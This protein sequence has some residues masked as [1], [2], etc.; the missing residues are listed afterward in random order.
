MNAVLEA[1][2]HESPMLRAVL[3]LAGGAEDRDARAL[4]ADQRPRHV[5]PVLRQQLIQVVA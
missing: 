1:K 2:H 3:Q 4:S 5:E